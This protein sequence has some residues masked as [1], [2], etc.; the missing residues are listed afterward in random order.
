MRRLWL[1]LG[2]VIASGL[3]S[4]CRCCP[5]MNPYANAVDDVSDSHLYLDNWYRP[6]WD[7]S[8]AG[9]PDW[10]GTQGRQRSWY[11]C[12][13]GTWGRYDDCNLYPT[14]YP[15]SYPGTAFLTVGSPG[16]RLVG[17]V[18]PVGWDQRRFAAPAHH[19]FSMFPD[20]GPALEASW[21][22][23]TLKKATALVGSPVPSTPAPAVAEPYEKPLNE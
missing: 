5:L 4:G 21:S 10:V 7:I 1:V 8:R 9:K 12:R 11:C 2:M 15:Y 16:H 19:D 14:S 23:P 3:S 13:E 18:Q 20:G 6:R 17:S 22:H